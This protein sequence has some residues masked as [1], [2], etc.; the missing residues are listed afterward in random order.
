MPTLGPPEDS[1]I[2]GILLPLTEY[3]GVRDTL[4]DVWLYPASVLVSG[5]FLLLCRNRLWIGAWLIG[6]AI[7]VLVKGTLARP[8]LH[9]GALHLVD[10]D[11]SLPSG[12]TIRSLL[13]AAALARAFPRVAPWAWAWAASVWI[14]LVAQGWHVPTD[15]AAGLLLASAL[16]LLADHAQRPR[17]DDGPAAAARRDRQPAVGEP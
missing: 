13:V 16:A 7:E 10:F 2:A 3:G 1:G 8:D 12:H 15:V 11:Q 14:L 9:Q 17:V 4:A 5:A 6:T